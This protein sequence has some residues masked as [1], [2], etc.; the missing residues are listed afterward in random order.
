M[1]A[2]PINQRSFILSRSVSVRTLVLSVLAAGLLAV[3]LSLAGSALGRPGGHGGPGGH[4][5][6]PVG[7]DVTYTEVHRFVNGSSVVSRF[8][9]GKLVSVSADSLTLAELDGSEVTVSYDANTALKAPKTI[10][11]IADI[12]VGTQLVTVREGDGAAKAVVLPRPDKQG[13]GDQPT[14][15]SR[16]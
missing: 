6:L 11:K 8:D 2:F 16:S 7:P 4:P 12:P 10:Q 1:L 14:H 9:Q 15:P 3:G 13:K 5:P